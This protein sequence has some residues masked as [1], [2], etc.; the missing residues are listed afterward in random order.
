MPI[1]KPKTGEKQREFI[2]RCMESIGNEYDDP[3]Q[4]IAVCF[5]EFKKDNYIDYQDIYDN[6]LYDLKLDIE[7]KNYHSARVRDPGEFQQKSFRT[8]T[9]PG[10]DVLIVIGRLKGK[11]TTTRQTYLFPKEK[12]T[13]AEV[14]AWL[15]KNNVKTIKIEP[16][17]KGG[18]G[19][20]D[21]QE[22]FEIEDLLKDLNEKKAKEILM[23]F[24]LEENENISDRTPGIR[25]ALKALA[26]TRKKNKKIFMALSS[27]EDEAKPFEVQGKKYSLKE[28]SRLIG[29][30]PK[31][32]I[33]E[34]KKKEKKD[35]ADNRL[36]QRFDFFEIKETGFLDGLE[37]SFQKTKEGFLS[38]R[39]I[40]TNIGV[41]PY[42]NS[43]GT[44][45]HE[46]RLPE[47]VMDPDSLETLKMKPISNEHPVEKVIDTENVKQHQVG[48][49]GSDVRNDAYHIS[50][51]VTITDQKAIEA[52]NNGKRALSAGYSL[53]LEEKPGTWM[54]VHYDAIQRNI[55]YNH[56]A[57][58][59][60]GRAGDA[61]KIRMDGAEK[62]SFY[63]SWSNDS[64]Q[65]KVKEDK[66]LNEN[67]KKITLDGVEYNAEAEVIKTVTGLKNRVDTLEKELTDLKTEKSTLEADRDTL[68][69]KV[70]QLEKDAAD[71][72]KIEER[73]HKRIVIL[74]A[75]EMA[76]INTD[77]KTEKEIMSEVILKVF[78]KANLKDRDD[79]YILGRFEGAVDELEKRVDEQKTK[80]FFGHSETSGG[81]EVISSDEARKRMI[82]RTYN[83]SRGIKEK[84]GGK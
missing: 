13:I 16:A 52:I 72:A 41:F 42:L 46:L 28:F 11:T 24:G 61:A 67:L 15:K 69:D 82:E 83:D 19:M 17:K 68:K 9:L 70:D 79:G 29:G 80:T 32:W 50:V 33:E 14:K 38:G 18:D 78:P 56:V 53:M 57:I 20:D 64:A 77:G 3:K 58:V 23:Q 65:N 37:E 55:R 49:T 76:G 31:S 6:D 73:V 8:K 35:N 47:E 22:D 39:A 84:E 36:V 59:D 51:P 12:Y 21:F 40:V 66:T 48:F 63:I 60:R 74:T 75:A 71:E 30:I 27:E 81:G 43:D 10:S 25:K 44:I 4:A 54:G 5:S 62:A 34:K 26:R 7:R 1:P 2:N 45:R